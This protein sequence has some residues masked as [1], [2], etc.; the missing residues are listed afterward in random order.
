MTEIALALADSTSEPIEPPFD[1]SA[2]NVVIIVLDDLGFAQLGCYGSDIDTPNLDR[3]AARGV[4]FTNFHTTAV[5]SPTRACLLTGRSHHRVGMGML[6]DMPVNYPG[7]TGEFPVGAGTLPEMLR[8]KGWATYAIGKWHLVPRDQRAAGPFHMWPTGV[9]FDRYYG[10]LNGET[11]QWTPNLVRDQTHVEPP[12]TPEQGYH[13]EADLADEAI[14]QLRELRLAQRTR[15]FLLWYATAAPHA[16]HQVPTEWIDRYAGR[17]DAGWDHWR[18]QTFARQKSLGVVPQDA[19]LSQRPSWVEEWKDIDADRRRLYARMM[20]VFAGFVSH[21]DHHI[22]R[23]IDEIEAAGELDDTIVVVISDNG[24]SA[25]GGPNGSWNQLRHYISDVPDDI[26]DELAHYDDLGGFRSS[27]HYPWGWALAGNTP[28]RRW[29]RYT[30]EGGVRDPLII[31]WPNGLAQRG[32]RNQYCHVTDVMPTL[33]DLLELDLPTELDGVAQMSIDGK[34]FSTVLRDDSAEPT[35]TT[36]YYE[37][38][39]SRAIYD[40]GFK[41]VTNHVNQLTAAERDHIEGSADFA[42][43]KWAL[44]DLAADFAE[45]HDLAEAQPDRLAELVALWHDQA[46]RNQ[47]LPIDDSAINRIGVLRAPWLDYAQRY[48]YR[49]GDK[50]H[51]VNSPLL[52][53]GYQLVAV[54]GP[55]IG[56][57][58]TGV[59]CEQG[60]WIS[61]W[62]VWLD[63]SSVHFAG[64]FNG[65]EVQASAPLTDSA[66]IL[67]LDVS[68]SGPDATNV[69][70]SLDGDQVG[71]AHLGAALPASYSPDGAFL[72]VGYGRPFPVSDRYDPTRRAPESFRALSLLPGTPP[73]FDYDAEFERV[74]RHQ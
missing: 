46:D 44:Y 37:C 20:E 30:F 65:R 62:A 74:M 51:E 42:T 8:A 67:S 5:C 2:P 49:P 68:P 50:A 22:G 28:F 64:V 48:D 32:L 55:E 73:P 21:A 72:T 57:G 34:S 23:V 1:P 35:R 56:S 66:R 25:E 59:I 45:N 52:S 71:E 17:F 13:L 61:G 33:M 47:V 18:E 27:G 12:S 26:S 63:K 9:G 53:G 36:Q 3:L 54:F 6:P 14:A 38:W 39:G 41:A 29:K 4:Q 31:S 15:P 7:Y 60:D 58:A 70:F 43:D 19:T 16:P 11:N 69:V 10:F 24:C 40:N